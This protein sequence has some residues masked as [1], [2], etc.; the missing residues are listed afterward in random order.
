[1]AFFA[2]VCVSNAEQ[3]EVVKTSVE[4]QMA[5]IK[6]QDGKLRIVEV[7]Q[8]IE[9]G[10]TVHGIRSNAVLLKTM[11]DGCI[12]ILKIKEAGSAINK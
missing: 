3:W 7:D 11:R 9:P 2:M 12:K 1:M 4:D 10:I 5:V 8:T 6:G